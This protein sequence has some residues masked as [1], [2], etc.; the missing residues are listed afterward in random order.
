MVRFVLQILWVLLMALRWV[1]VPIIGLFGGFAVIV[2][3]AGCVLSFLGGLWVTVL[4]HHIDPW[5]CVG[6]FAV[7]LGCLVGAFVVLG[8]S[9]VNDP[10]LS[11]WRLPSFGDVHEDEF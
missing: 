3:G 4:M 7:S 10:S 9:A 11:S 2:L 5:A 1:M 8:I 6:C